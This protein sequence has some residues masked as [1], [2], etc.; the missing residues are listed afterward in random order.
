MKIN[1]TFC[2]PLQCSGINHVFLFKHALLQGLGSIIFKYPDLSLNDNGAVVQ[3]RRN[4]VN[5]GPVDSFPGF[6]C[7]FMGIQAAELG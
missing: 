2:Y 3:L 4:I 1:F 7:P 5:G 6:Q